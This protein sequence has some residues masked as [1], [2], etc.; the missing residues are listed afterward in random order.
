MYLF[1]FFYVYYTTYWHLLRLRIDVSPFS[2]LSLKLYSL[3][4]FKFTDQLV[5]S[6][7]KV[8]LCNLSCHTG[9]LAYWT[10]IYNKHLFKYLYLIFVPTSHHKVNRKQGPLLLCSHARLNCH[11]IDEERRTTLFL[12]DV[13]LIDE[14]VVTV[15]LSKKKFSFFFTFWMTRF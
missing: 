11:H 14:E 7:C 6:L 5:M 1:I 13:E 4:H 8:Y 3:E 9:N 2:L 15:S 12:F 10:C